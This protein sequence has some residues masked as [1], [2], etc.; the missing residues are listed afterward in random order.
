M[1]EIVW[2]FNW[3]F[4]F[5]KKLIFKCYCAKFAILTIE[6]SSSGKIVSEEKSDFF[7]E[8]AIGGAFNEHER[9]LV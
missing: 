8:S 7:A 9:R 2:S 4:V 1:I 5:N 3:I 6:K